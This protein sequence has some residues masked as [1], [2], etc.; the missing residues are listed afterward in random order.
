MD[1]LRM[2]YKTIH[3]GVK[4]ECK[5]CG[6]QCAQKNNLL[7]HI[8]RYHKTINKNDQ[9][10]VAIVRKEDHKCQ[11]CAETYASKIILDRHTKMEH[12]SETVTEQNVSEK[13]PVHANFDV[14]E[15]ITEN[16][17]E[18][19][20][21]EDSHKGA[22]SL[23]VMMEFN[24]DV[25]DFSFSRESNLKIHM[26]ELHSAD[27]AGGNGRYKFNKIELRN[28]PYLKRLIVPLKLMFQ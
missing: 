20:Q 25:C 7:V 21:T 5:V 28:D 4:F 3:G 26:E 27:D 15:D 6:K 13:A 19:N 2:H 23:K 14:V 1:N 17:P 10:L 11:H 9:N 8:K 22:K 12:K 18:E 24:C 16:N